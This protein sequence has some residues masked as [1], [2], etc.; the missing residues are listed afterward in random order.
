MS[1]AWLFPGQGTQRRGMGAHVFD[2]YPGLVAKAD[3]ILGY[4]VRELCLEDPDGKLATTEYCQPALFVVNA[5]L[6]LEKRRREPWP[7]FIAGHSLGEFSALFAAGSFEFETGVRIVLARARCMATAG[8]G[9][10]LAVIGLD[11]PQLQ[12]VIAELGLIGLDVANYNLRTQTVL[13]GPD[14][15]IEALDAVLVAR[16][17]ART[18][19][20]HVG[21][22]FHS[23]YAAGAAGQFREMLRAYELVD[24]KLPTLSSATGRP[25]RP[26]TVRAVLES[27]I[28]RPVR[29]VET[30]QFLHEHGV[31]HA[32]QIGPGRVLDGLWERFE[33]AAHGLPG[34]PQQFATQ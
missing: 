17:M 30:M 26:G 20:L 3:E 1:R 19:H 23:R 22:A 14:P 5:L 12:A 4:S 27:Q 18:V 6:F 10:M 21:G 25:Y 2:L 32:A 13:A 11:L 16:E 7:E 9:S 33:P 29:W 34:R 31:T 15:D 8:T 24:P 28:V